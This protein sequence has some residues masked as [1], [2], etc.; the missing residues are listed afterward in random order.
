MKRIFSTVLVLG[1]AGNGTGQFAHAETA[2]EN[3]PVTA[4]LQQTV[5]EA[6][7][8]EDTDQAP[9]QFTLAD[10]Q[11]LP[12]SGFRTTTIW[13]EG[14]QHFEGVWLKDLID[15]LG[16]EDGVVELSA[17]NEYMIEIDTAEIADSEALVAY[18]RN[19]ELMSVRDKGPLWMVF[20]YDSDPKFR[21]ETT[22]AHSIWQLDRIVHLK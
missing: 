11:N 22:Y 21:T 19:G 4:Q 1:L 15:H 7:F 9:V 18:M 5:L 12:R 3:S 17:L 6:R 20:P 2:T 8:G 14:E 13:T 16:F 10:L